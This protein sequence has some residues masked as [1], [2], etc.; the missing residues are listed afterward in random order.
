MTLP[1]WAGS[2]QGAVKGLGKKDRR[3]G[4]HYHGNTQLEVNIAQS[5]MFEH[6]DHGRPHYQG[7]TGADGVDLRN[8]EDQQAAGNEEATANPEEAAQGAHDYP[9]K[10][11]E[12]WIYDH[13]C[14]GEEHKK[15]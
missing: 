8:S 11:Q 12:N 1:T 13:I 6:I 4:A 10:D 14:I 9:Q 3:H 7:E 2:L 15:S 5:P